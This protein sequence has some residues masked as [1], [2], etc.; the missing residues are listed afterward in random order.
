VEGSFFR[1]KAGVGIRPPLQSG[2]KRLRSL[3][4]ERII[5]VTAR[6]K[7][8]KR[9]TVVGVQRQPEPDAL[10]Q[11]GIRD[12]MPSEGH[13]IAITLSNGSLGSV[14]FKAARRNNRSRANIY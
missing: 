9:V 7:S 4:I 13:Q 11:V 5:R 3:F 8:V 6:V 10:G 2:S 12:E 14:R 1:R